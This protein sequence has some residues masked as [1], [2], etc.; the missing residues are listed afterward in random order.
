M[1]YY[2][3]SLTVGLL[4]RSVVTNSAGEFNTSTEIAVRLLM[5]R[6]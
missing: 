5:I 3:P 6:Y 1:E 2:A 4:P